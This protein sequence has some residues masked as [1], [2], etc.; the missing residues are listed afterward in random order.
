[1]PADWADEPRLE[2]ARWRCS[3]NSI[4][5]RTSSRSTSSNVGRR[6]RGRERARAAG[7]RCGTAGWA[8]GAR[9]NGMDGER[10]GQGQ[11]RARAR[12]RAGRDQGRAAPRQGQS[13]PR[14]GAQA[15]QRPHSGSWCQQRSARRRYGSGQSSRNSG[16][17]VPSARGRQRGG[18]APTQASGRGSAGAQERQRCA[19]A[20][21]WGATLPGG[22]TASRE[23]WATTPP[24][25]PQQHEPPAPQCCS[26]RRHPLPANLA[27]RQRGT[28]QRQPTACRVCAAH[29]R[30]PGRSARRSGPRT[31]PCSRTSPTLAE[32]GA[33]R[34]GREEDVGR[35]G[36]A[37]GSQGFGESP[38]QAAA[39]LALRI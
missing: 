17:S 9:A 4:T 13:T 31:A 37:H 1:M 38:Q 26:R 5:M 19:G 30:R 8:G 7:P 34:R 23:A 11:G 35:G 18:D 22:P 21:G 20:T 29:P 12:A 33:R 3:R 16:R 27:A 10:P 2:A 39:A 6:L 36:G 14:P 28:A 15:G 32:E 24:R 25:S